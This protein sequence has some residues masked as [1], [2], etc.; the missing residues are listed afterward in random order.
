MFIS[1]FPVVFGI[2]QVIG[3][4]LMSW[5]CISN[6]E[7]QKQMSAFV[8]GRMADRKEIDRLTQDTQGNAAEIAAIRSVVAGLGRQ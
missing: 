5:L 7:L 4:G 6:I 3:V 1:A 2:L 8:E